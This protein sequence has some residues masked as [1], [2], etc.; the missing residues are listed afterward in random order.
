MKNFFDAHG[1]VHEHEVTA[2][3]GYPGNNGFVHTGYYYVAGGEV[4]LDKVNACFEACRTS[5][6]Y[7]RHPDK[8][9][10]PASSHDEL[11]G[12]FLI[13]TK[14]QAKVMYER[15]KAQ[16]WQACNLDGFKPRSLW[17]LNPFK[18]MRDFYKLNK[19]PNPRKATHKYPYI[20]PIT[21]RHMPQHT[22]FYARCA[23]ERVGFF[24]TVWFT[25]SSMFTML[26]DKN[27]SSK[28]ML[29]FKLAKL[30]TLGIKE[31]EGTILEIYDE[32]IDMYDMALRYYEDESHPTVKLLKH[33]NND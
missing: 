31:I 28:L 4:D 32:E 19:E 24:H 2:D 13:A 20:W 33:D 21:F 26:K 29:G 8:D 18:V 10:F 30:R 6:G 17:S 27:Y 14:Q 16:G 3:D 15:Y 23:G 25:L 12:M 7:D 22:Y 9:Q 1:R 11:V 5:Y